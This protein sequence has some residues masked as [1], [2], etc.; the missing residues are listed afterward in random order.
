MCGR[1]TENQ[2]RIKDRAVEMNQSGHGQDLDI[3]GLLET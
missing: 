1:Q 3:S 2:N